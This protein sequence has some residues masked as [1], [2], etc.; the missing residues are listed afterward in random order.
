M[1]VVAVTVHQT[2]TR[3]ERY[4]TVSR[5][6]R[7]RSLGRK[8]VGG[9]YLT[10]AGVHLGVVAADPQFYATFAEDALVPALRTAWDE[11]F[12]AQPVLWG[13]ALC[14]AEVAIGTMLLTGGRWT[15]PG[16]SL[17]VAFHVM[18]VLM[19]GP[20]ILVWVVP[21]LAIVVPLAV[22]DWLSTH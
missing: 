11:I 7:R 22:A 16:W 13:T 5:T 18:L 12:M 20:W 4:E 17:V 3:P 10:M 2:Y 6:G 9:F 21:A 8:L 1:E 14:L 19:V 15:M